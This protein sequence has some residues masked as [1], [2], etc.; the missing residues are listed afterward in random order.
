VLCREELRSKYEG[1]LTA[2]MSGPSYRVVSKL[3]RALSGGKPAVHPESFKT[4]LNSLFLSCRR[5]VVQ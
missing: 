5:M 4:Y 1:Q 3:L 2:E